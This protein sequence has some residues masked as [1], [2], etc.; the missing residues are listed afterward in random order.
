MK[1]LFSLATGSFIALIAILLHQSFPPMGVAASIFLSYSSIWW[2]GRQFSSRGLK[3]IAAL[4]W[5]A[6]LFRGATFGEGQELLIQGD[7]VG[8]SLITIGTIAVLAA[9][10]ARS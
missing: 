6:V 10:A 3:W 7:A 2:I 4:G 9:V 5:I 1:Q 8:T